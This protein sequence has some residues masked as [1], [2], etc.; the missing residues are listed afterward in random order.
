M[1]EAKQMTR[2]VC[3][4]KLKEY[5]Y[6]TE[7]FAIGKGTIETG[8]GNV[9]FVI[10]NSGANATNQHTKAAD[11][12][13]EFKEGDMIFLTG[14][15]SR[16]YSE[17]KDTYYESIQVWDYRKA[18]E[19]EINRWVYVYVADIKELTDDLVT[20]SF[21]NYKKEEMTFPLVIDKNTKI[22]G[23]L[24]VGARVKAKGLIFNGLKADF[25]GD[26]EFVTERTAVDIKL[27]HTAEEL[28]PKE[29][30]GSNSETPGMWD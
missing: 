3:I 14:S 8:K 9:Q 17:E 23:E 11:F 26:G 13:K 21:V 24:H 15:D 10:F 25:F 29:G 2:V 16:S 28:A 5:K 27:L 22:D 4:G 7:G 20:L 1:A 30:E 12:E 6:T 19:G 18:E